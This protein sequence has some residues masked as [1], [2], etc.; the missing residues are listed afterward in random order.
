MGGVL[1]ACFVQDDVWVNVR[2]INGAGPVRDAQCTKNIAGL[3]D[4]PLQRLRTRSS[5][6][7]RALRR[8]ALRR[9]VAAAWTVVLLLGLMPVAAP[10]VAPN[11]PLIRDFNRLALQPT[12]ASPF[13]T[14]FLGR[15]QLS[16]IIYGAR[17]SLFMALTAT[18][19]GVSAGALWGLA[20]GYLGGQDDLISERVQEIIAS[21]PALIMAMLLAFLLGGSVWTVIVAIAFTKIVAGTRVIRSVALPVWETPYVDTARSTGASQ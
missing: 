2:D 12:W 15:D 14:D 21:V 5:R 1:S 10:M 6:Y 16:R 4:E 3:P 20:S 17:F 13:G 11:D 9:Q 7:A 8:F 19:F 18:L